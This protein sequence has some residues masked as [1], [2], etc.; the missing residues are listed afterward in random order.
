MTQ[1][2]E[3]RVCLG[4]GRQT[5]SITQYCSDGEC[6]R[7]Q[8]SIL[9]K[10]KKGETR[11]E[12]IRECDYIHRDGTKCKTLTYV[13]RCKRHIDSKTLTKCAKCETYT[14]REHGICGYCKMFTKV[15]VIE[16]EVDAD[17]DSELNMQNLANDIEVEG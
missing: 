15:I 14:F 1:P 8:K 3:K 10:S 2:R 6:G 13:M 17:S 11:G 5:I 12:G 7:K 16:T 4:C 9:Y